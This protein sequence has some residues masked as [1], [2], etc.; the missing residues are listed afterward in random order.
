MSDEQAF[1][2][3]D[4]SKPLIESL[5]KARLGRQQYYFNQS[6]RRLVSLAHDISASVL[7]LSHLRCLATA[8]DSSDI[9]ALAGSTCVG[10]VISR[11]GKTT[12]ALSSLWVG[13]RVSGTYVLL[14]ERVSLE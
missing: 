14:Y 12:T 3:G 13:R 11:R 2:C 6:S 8:A 9:Q 1:R 4:L 10:S 5:D 7:W